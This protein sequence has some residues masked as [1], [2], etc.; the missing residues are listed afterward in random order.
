MTV[1]GPVLVICVPARIAKGV[2][3]P[4]GTGIAMACAGVG[5][6]VAT[7]TA[8]TAAIADAIKAGVL[9]H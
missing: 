3:V 7:A 5:V 2:T 4:R 6:T 9:R 8:I 1:E